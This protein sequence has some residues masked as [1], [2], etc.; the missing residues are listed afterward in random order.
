[1]E[2]EEAGKGPAWTHREDASSS[3]EDSSYHLL[4]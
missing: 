3:L 4:R 2:S 1:M